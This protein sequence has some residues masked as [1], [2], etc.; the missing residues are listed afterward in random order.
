MINKKYSFY[1]I[2]FF[3]LP[4]LCP[5]AQGMKV[6]FTSIIL[7]HPNENNSSVITTRYRLFEILSITLVRLSKFD[8]LTRFYVFTLN[9]FFL[10]LPYIKI[11]KLKY[12]IA[13]IIYIT[14][15]NSTNI[16]KFIVIIYLLIYRHVYFFFSFHFFF[17]HCNLCI[18]YCCD[19]VL[20][21]T[22][23]CAY[24]QWIQRGG[25]DVGW[26]VSLS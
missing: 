22:I 25:V 6:K 10:L 4:S 3:R 16:I 11:I 8:L 1:V 20:T 15:T 23:V 17:M 18:F 13:I 19:S 26:V 12:F 24:I 7:R 2:V 21:I 9:I 5:C 14:Q